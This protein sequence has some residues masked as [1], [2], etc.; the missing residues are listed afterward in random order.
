MCVIYVAACVLQAVVLDWLCMFTWTGSEWSVRQDWDCPTFF[1]IWRALHKSVC[2]MHTAQ[3]SMLYAHCT[4]QYAV[5]TLH[6]SVC[7]MRGQA[8]DCLFPAYRIQYKCISTVHAVLQDLEY[9][10]VCYQW[11]PC[12]LTSH[13]APSHL[14][15]S[16]H[17]TET[18]H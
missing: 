10:K 4:S 14:S 11:V 17:A 3:V 12:L 6:K 2:C 7:C 16:R 9:Y 13:I 18:L 5:C 8:K 1:L 15:I